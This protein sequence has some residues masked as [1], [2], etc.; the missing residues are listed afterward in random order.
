[1]YIES[2]T[3]FS[4]R[5]KYF[6][7]IKDMKGYELA[8][9]LGVSASTVSLWLSGKRVPSDDHKYSMCDIFEI[10]YLELLHTEDEIAQARIEYLFK[11]YDLKITDFERLSELEDELALLFLKVVWKYQKK[12]D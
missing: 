6:L 1:M 2:I 7:R 8:E 4:E 3:P 11:K 9:R 10:S 5:L 12:G